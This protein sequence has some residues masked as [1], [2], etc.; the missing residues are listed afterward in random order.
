MPSAKEK[1]K[2]SNESDPSRSQTGSTSTN[3]Q[4]DSTSSNSGTNTDSTGAGAPESTSLRQTYLFNPAA[5]DR[6]EREAAAAAAAQAAADRGDNQEEGLPVS[7][8]AHTMRKVEMLRDQE[9]IKIYAEKLKYGTTQGAVPLNPFANPGRFKTLREVNLHVTQ[10]NDS[11]PATHGCEQNEKDQTTLVHK[12]LQSI[13]NIQRELTPVA[14]DTWRQSCQGLL[15]VN[16]HNCMQTL[17]DKTLS[18]EARY[19][20]EHM[21]PS[22]PL[23][24]KFWLNARPSPRDP[25]TYE[26]YLD[27]RGLSMS[28]LCDLMAII[29][30]ALRRD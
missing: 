13:A 9:F 1:K 18:I 15:R 4:M 27:W 14:I 5:R 7:Q 29:G 2:D 23:Q 30:Q 26:L 10:F 20:V 25:E 8:L 22:L 28:R 17:I 6:Q 19:L 3:P 21:L 24:G 12:Q 11:V 16:D